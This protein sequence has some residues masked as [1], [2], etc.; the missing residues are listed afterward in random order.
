MTFHHGWF[1]LVFIL[2]FAVA[3]TSVAE[4]SLDAER[5]SD[6]VGVSAVTTP[7]GVVRVAWPRNDVPLRVDGL[8]VRAAMGLGTWAAFQAVPGNSRCPGTPN[9]KRQEKR[10][11]KKE[12]APAAT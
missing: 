11:R 6:I 1:G 10:G 4:T 2:T 9:A 5:I 7:D 8:A 3:H 12:A